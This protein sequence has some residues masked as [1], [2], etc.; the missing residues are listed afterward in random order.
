[1]EKQQ[2]YKC[3]GCGVVV[4]VLEGGDCGL[5]CG[6]SEMVLQEAKTADRS[7]EKHVPFIEKVDGGYKVRIGEN[8]AHPMEEDH[9]IQ[10]I[11][12]Q[13]DQMISKIF[14]KPGDAPEAFFRVGDYKAARD[15]PAAREH[16]NKHGLW[17]G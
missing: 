9:Y 3:S 10:W 17:K 8:A 14:L 15:Q 7:A 16:C 12:L 13:C 11:E 5:C 4:E 6:D 1:M 2:I